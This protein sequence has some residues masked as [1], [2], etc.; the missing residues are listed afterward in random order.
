M[1]SEHNDKFSTRFMAGEMG[2]QFTEGTADG[3]FKFLGE[4][5]A[6]T[7]RALLTAMDLEL[8]QGFEQAVR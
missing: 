4:F 3:F 6:Y 7:A 8:G 1:T 2:N 5:P